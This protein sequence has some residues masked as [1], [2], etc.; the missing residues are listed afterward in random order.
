ME[1]RV[2]N[3]ATAPTTPSTDGTAMMQAMTAVIDI[4]DLPLVGADL[5]PL[6]RLIDLADTEVTGTVST[7]VTKPDLAGMKGIEVGIVVNTTT[8][9]IATPVDMIAKTDVTMTVTV[10]AHPA[11]LAVPHPHRVIAKN[12]LWRTTAAVATQGAISMTDVTLAET[13]AQLHVLQRPSKTPGNWKKNVAANW[14]RCNPMPLIWNQTGASV[15]QKFPQRNKS[16]RRRMTASVLS[17]VGSCL[18]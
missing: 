15:S 4:G 5:G 14:Q 16:S 13:P 18:M 8:K 11:A 17:A 10:C 3:A 12:A 2:V 7:G 9:E 1:E 6:L